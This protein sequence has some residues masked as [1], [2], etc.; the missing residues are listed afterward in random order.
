MYN[1]II[2][3]GLALAAIGF[4]LPIATLVIEP[5]LFKTDM[6]FVMLISTIYTF[7]ACL[8]KDQ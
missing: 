5:E 4:L 1:A 8:A 2:N 3:I 6:V 7:F